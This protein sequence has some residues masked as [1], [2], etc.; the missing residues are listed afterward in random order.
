MNLNSL[1][2]NYDKE[3]NYPLYLGVKVAPHYPFRVIVT[4]QPQPHPQPQLLQNKCDKYKYFLENCLHQHFNQH[5]LCQLDHFH[6]K[7]CIRHFNKQWAEKYKE[8]TL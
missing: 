4:P 6:F 8:K 5:K 3:I 1:Q 2:K 7:S